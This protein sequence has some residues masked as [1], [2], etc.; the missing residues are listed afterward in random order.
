[1][2]LTPDNMT[3]AQV[4]LWQL[5]PPMLLAKMDGLSN[6]DLTFFI[7]GLT[8]IYQRD[9]KNPRGYFDADKFFVQY[10]DNYRKCPQLLV[11]DNLTSEVVFGNEKPNVRTDLNVRAD[12][13]LADQK[14]RK[15][16]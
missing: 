5:S 14:Y 6:M 9:L 16:E 15:G 10:A 3:I 2:A 1:M 7:G 8:N 13:W 4:K 12:D 11:W